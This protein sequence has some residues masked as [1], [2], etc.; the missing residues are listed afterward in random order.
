[1]TPDC[2]SSLLSSTVGLHRALHW[3]LLNPVLSAEQAH[4]A[5]M[6]AQVHPATELAAAARSVVDALL[7]GSREA[8]VAT[9][10]LLRERTVPGAEGAMRLEALSIRAAAATGDGLEGIAA[11]LDKRQPDFPSSRSGRSRDASA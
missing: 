5:G 6:V 10:R 11:F 1:L 9:K 4:Q 3:A 7:L 2:G 8:Q